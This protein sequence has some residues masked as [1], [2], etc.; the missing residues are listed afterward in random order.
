MCNC[1]EDLEA[2]LLAQYI[3]AEPKARDHGAELKGYTFVM[4]EKIT[5]KGKM[6]IEYSASFTVKGE[7]KKRKRTG[8]MIFTYCPFCGKKYDE[9]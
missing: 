6:D 5:V 1:K 4:G 7:F 9:E 3:S 8:T 2:K